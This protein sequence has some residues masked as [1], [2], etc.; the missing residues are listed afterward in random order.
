MVSEYW[1]CN[2]CKAMFISE[3]DVRIHKCVTRQSLTEAVEKWNRLEYGDDQYCKYEDIQ[4]EAVEFL[5]REL[6]L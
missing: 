1:K 2:K 5:V 3:A 6:G 4:K